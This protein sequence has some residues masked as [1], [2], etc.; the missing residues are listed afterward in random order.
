MTE[1]T[2]GRPA[3]GD[4]HS[5]LEEGVGVVHAV[6][7]EQAGQRREIAS[8]ELAIAALTAVLHELVAARRAD[9]EVLRRIL[10]A[11]TREASGELQ[12]AIRNMAAAIATMGGDVRAILAAVGP[13][14]PPG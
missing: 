12:E 5:L 6:R 1:G 13:R 11:C 9:H 2:T 3:I 4:L 8:L 14:P 7:A 10:E